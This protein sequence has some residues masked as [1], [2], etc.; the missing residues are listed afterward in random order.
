MEKLNTHFEQ[1]PLEAI[2]TL[3]QEPIPNDKNAEQFEQ[4]GEKGSETSSKEED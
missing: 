2:K 1:V 4:A 3:V